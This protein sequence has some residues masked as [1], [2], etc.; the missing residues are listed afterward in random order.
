MFDDCIERRPVMRTGK[1]RMDK[2]PPD[3]SLRNISIPKFSLHT[4]VV[5]YNN[6]FN[7]TSI[8]SY[9]IHYFND[10]KDPRQNSAVPE[11]LN[12]DTNGTNVRTFP[13]WG[14]VL[15]ADTPVSDFVEE[16]S[17]LIGRPAREPL[18]A[19]TLGK[20]EEESIDTCM[21][22]ETI[23]MAKTEKFIR[24]GNFTQNDHTS[25]LGLRGL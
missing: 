15:R 6:R 7:V 9:L 25:R 23:H 13:S 21:N 18:P 17:L 11:R 22:R 10:L 2:S 14:C 24:R 5:L 16:L 12:G 19:K 20:K 4:N 3:A 8:R 1:S